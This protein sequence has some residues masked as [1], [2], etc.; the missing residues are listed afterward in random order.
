MIRE[1]PYRLF[2]PLG[3][4]LGLAGAALW[5]LM[6][7]GAI[8][9]YPKEIHADTMMGGFLVLFV[10]GFLMTALPRFTGTPGLEGWELTLFGA[11]VL[12]VFS[13]VFL[14]NRLPF[15]FALLINLV[16]L[17]LFCIRRIRE[18]TVLPPPPL[19]FVFAGL[20]GGIASLSCFMLHDLGGGAEFF[21]TLAQ[22]FFYQGFQLCLVL[23]VGIFLIPN[24]LGH[25]TCT[26]PVTIG[27]RTPGS[28]HLPYLRFVPKPLWVV[29]ALFFLSFYIQADVSERA[30]FA[31]RA[32]ILALVSFH[33]WKIH[34]LPRVRSTVSIGLW[35]SCWLLVAGLWLQVL[36]PS[37]DIHARHLTYIGGFGLMTFLIA[38]RVT[39]AHGGHDMTLET[40]SRLLKAAIGLILLAA[41]TRTI[42]RLMPEPVYLHHLDYAAWSWISGLALWGYLCL[43]RMFHE[44][45]QGGEAPPPHD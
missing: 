34:R 6:L 12:G 18:R 19:I 32:A 42:A 45:N 30:G 3:W 20:A 29:I 24:L 35:A 31:I 28:Q 15:H 16:F 37:Y 22:L 21:K 41:F 8:A 33:D 36:R 10:A 13:T 27:I 2:F 11:S 44:G 17:L 25:P 7:H 5:P 38:T 9:S 23:G 14:Q 39:L 4:L 26:P 1:N 40:K 43:P